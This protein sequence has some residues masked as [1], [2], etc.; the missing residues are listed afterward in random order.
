MALIGRHSAVVAT[1]GTI[2]TVDNWKYHTFTS[3]GNFVPSTTGLVEY[4]CVA[5]G[6]GGGSGN[7]GPSASGG[8][9]GAG[10][11]ITDTLHVTPQTYAVVIGAGGTGGNDKGGEKGDNSTITAGSL[12]ITAIGGGGGQC[13]PG[14][15]GHEG[16]ANTTIGGSGGGGDYTAGGNGTDGQGTAGGNGHA[17]GG[18]TEWSTPYYGGGGGGAGQKGRAKDDNQHSAGNGRNGDG[19]RGR[20][21]CGTFY[22]GGGGSGVYTGSNTGTGRGGVG[23]RRAERRPAGEGRDARDA[24]GRQERGGVQRT[25]AS[26][27]LRRGERRRELPPEPR[28][29]RRLECRHRST[30]PDSLDGVQL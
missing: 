21:W 20:Q 24:R 27:G 18:V 22:A 5:G 26:A 12:T 7:G 8:G 4:L 1:G 28:R 16:A 10:G 30:V 6:G 3:S 13:G 11:M 2:T 17:G 25:A 29:H 23:G 19:G 14:A 9:G 15:V